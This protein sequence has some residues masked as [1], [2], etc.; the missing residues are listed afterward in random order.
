MHCVHPDEVDATPGAKRAVTDYAVLSALGQRVSWCA[1]V[2]VTGRT[3]Q[4][5]A[6]MAE[7]GHPIVGDGKYGGSGQENLGDGWGAQL[8]GE[9]S[10]KLH[11]HARSLTLTHPMTG[12]AAAPDRAACPITWRAPGRRWN[13]TRRMC[14]PTR[15]RTSNERAAPRG[16][17]RRWHAGRQPG[18]YPGRDGPGPLR[19]S[20]ARRPRAGRAW[21]RRPVAA[22]GHG[23]ACPTRRMPCR[24]SSMPTRP[25]SR[26]CASRKTVSPVPA[27]SR[28]AGLPG[29]A[30]A[31]PWTL[32]G[33]AT[34][35]SRRGLAHLIELHDLGSTFQTVQVADDH[36]S[37]PHP[38]MLEAC[39]A[40]PGSSPSM[41]PWSATPPTTSRWGAPRAFGPSACPGAIT[42]SALAGCGCGCG[43]RRFCRLAS[44][45]GR[46]LQAHDGWKAKRFWTE[47]PRGAD[48]GGL[49]C[50]AR[51]RPDSHTRQGRLDLPTEAMAEAIAANGRRRGRGNR[52]PVHA[53]H[54]I[55]QFGHRPGGDPAWRGGGDAGRLCGNRP[56]VPP[57]R[58]PQR[59]VRPAGEG[60][61]P[62]LDW[63]EAVSARGS[64][65]PPASCRSNSRTSA[66]SAVGNVHGWAPFD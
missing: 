20:A 29:G 27:L 30:G 17:R 15:S 45:L 9:I 23:A 3:H 19:P 55:R 1:L 34:G 37:K 38:A 10:R 51:Q 14:R 61:D 8:G 32:L 64:C 26:R 58:Q 66:Q 62:L 33:V 40:E 16:L 2:P 39:L 42:R 13:G 47:T 25:L 7:M 63:A 11:L 31:E 48:R 12:R 24:S 35:K 54:T 21:H 52:P 56:V 43:D 49:A 28:R 5:R 4:L 65:R 44:A 6:H 53:G 57:R 22:G 36:P 18:A 59:P 46:G 41:P 60:W 50:P